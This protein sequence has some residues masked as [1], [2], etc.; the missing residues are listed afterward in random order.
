[1]QADANNLEQLDQQAFQFYR[2]ALAAVQ[3]SGVPFLVGGAYAFGYYTGIVRH[4]KDF[5]FFTRPDDAPRVLEVLRAAG[6]HTEIAF[7]HWLGKA[8]HEGNFVDVIFNS[9]NGT[10]PVDDVWFKHAVAGEV[11]GVPARLCPAEEMIWQKAYIMERERYDGADVAHL[12]RA[13]GPKLDW[14]R[15]LRRFGPNWR[16]LLGHLVLFGFIYP[17]ER[18]KIPEQ[19]LATLIDRLHLEM[20]KAAPSSSVCRGTLLSRMQYLTDT[21]QWGYQDARLAPRGH[22]TMEEIEEWTAAGLNGK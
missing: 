11:L 10:C 4:T 14:D 12:I 9:G 17:A 3:R 1:M 22:M 18:D 20:R 2:D 7:P 8:F 6:Y 13:R 5:D 15:L 21:E 19:V 16:V